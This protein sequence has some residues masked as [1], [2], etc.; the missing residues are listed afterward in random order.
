MIAIT[1][2]LRCSWLWKISKAALISKVFHSFT[3]H[4][5][6]LADQ[7][8]VGSDA[9][10]Y[11]QT[12]TTHRAVDL[13]LVKVNSF[14]CPRLPGTCPTRQGRRYSDTSSP[15]LHISSGSHGRQ[16]SKANKVAHPY[17]ALSDLRD[18]SSYG[19]LSG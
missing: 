5:F 16:N 19:F 9:R 12:S 11:H 4:L 14:L 1:F 7:V 15:P 8:L 13:T 10:C 3:K 17:L 2:A 6:H 18:R